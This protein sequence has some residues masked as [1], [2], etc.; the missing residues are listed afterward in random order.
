MPL[1]PA[2][3]RRRIFGTIA[4]IATA[5]AL[6]TAAAAVPARAGD[7]DLARALTAVAVLA[8]IAST[9]DGNRRDHD[10]HD[11]SRRYLPA[12]CAVDLRYRRGGV[13]YAEPC[14]RRYGVSGP[15]PR[16]CA[17]GT[18]IRGRAV[19][20]FPQGCLIDAGFRPARGR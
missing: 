8:L 14:L 18:R 17:T 5:L 7:R 9:I 10:D 12:Q 13:V 11:R 2:P 1:I 16:H 3:V 4:I 15:L 19:T 6:M 20:V